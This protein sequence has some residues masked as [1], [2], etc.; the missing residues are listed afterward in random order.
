MK[1][2]VIAFFLL[3]CLSNP[4][5]AEQAMAPDSHERGKMVLGEAIVLFDGKSL[6][7]WKGRKDLWTVEE[8]VIVGRTTE[9]SPIKQNTFLIFENDAIKEGK[10]KNF[11]LALLFKIESGNSG[12]QYRSKMIDEDRF[13]V[14]GY[15]AD[16]DFENRFA[17][18]LY[19]EKGRGILAQRGESVTID[20]DGEKL[21]KRFADAKALGNGI[22]PGQWNDFRIVARGNRLEHYVNGAKTAELIDNQTSKAASSGVIG[23]QLHR[24]PAMTV[25]FKNIVLTPY[26]PASVKLESTEE[27]E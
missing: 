12:I 3:T 22:H 21:R 24:G 17:G 9:E 26:L 13:V 14:G 23:L 19:E 15:Q 11:E 27:G 20:D 8:G 2:T 25:R 18:I 10:P 7:G 4:V 5:W 16:I 1:F 6:D